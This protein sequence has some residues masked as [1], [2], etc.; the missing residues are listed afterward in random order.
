MNHVKVIQIGFILP[1]YTK[2]WRT[3]FLSDLVW[4]VAFSSYAHLIFHTAYNG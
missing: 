2:T 3:H 4:I 1:N